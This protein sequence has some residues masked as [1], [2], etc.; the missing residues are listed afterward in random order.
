MDYGISSDPYWI[1]QWEKQEIITQ[2]INKNLNPV[3]HEVVS[4]EITT[5][6]DDLVITIIDKDLIGSG[7]FEGRVVIHMDSLRD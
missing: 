4:F 7:D 1:L 5:G 6:K 2:V 3:W